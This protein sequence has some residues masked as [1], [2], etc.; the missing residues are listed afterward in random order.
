[1][2]PTYFPTAAA[3]RR[4]LTAH[5][6]RERELLVGFHQVT[7]G[8]PGITYSEALD[9]AL[10]FGWIDGVRKSVDAG[11]YT[12]RFT[13]RKRASYWSAV[14]TRRAEAL[15][16]SGR[17]RPVGLHAF[18]A[19]D[20]EKT[21]KYSF[22]REAMALTPAF[23]RAFRAKARAWAFFSAQPPGYR[24]VAT[25][26]VMNAKQEPTRQRRLRQLIADSAA[27]LRLAQLTGSG[28]R[29]AK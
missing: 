4:W 1:V 7:S 18:E 2:E 12:I 5:H 27:G 13:P 28:T 11:R 17:M 21:A 15:I 23:E 9:E 22:E 3:F 14:N 26:W 20:R 8:H 25:Y 19:R 24:R 10:C 16:E 6:A 29:R